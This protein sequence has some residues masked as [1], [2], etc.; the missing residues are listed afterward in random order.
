MV[1]AIDAA[2]EAALA[3]LMAA[4]VGL[5]FVAVVFR[6]VLQDPVTW[7]EEVGRFCLVWI[8]FL[9]TYIAHRRAEHIAVT[10]IRD[11]FPVAVQ[12]AVRAALALL[13]IAFMAVLTWYGGQ[14]A[15]RFMAMQT[16]LL[17][18]PLGLVYAAMPVSTGLILVSLVLSSIKALGRGR[19]DIGGGLG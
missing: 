4:V 5:V 9:G 13:L 7:S 19:D 17:R 10:A 14:Y 15:I 3:L 16:S 6:Y 8:S 12:I 2:V 18:I 11:R 1:R